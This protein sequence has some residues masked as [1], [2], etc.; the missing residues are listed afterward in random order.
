MPGCSIVPIG[1]SASQALQEEGKIK[2]IGLNNT[3]VEQL[4]EAWATGVRFH[5]LQARRSLQP[6][7]KTKLGLTHISPTHMK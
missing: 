4:D 2:Y 6:A 7:G 1:S 3:T 5:T